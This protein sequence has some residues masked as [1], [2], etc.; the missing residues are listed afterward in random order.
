M[1]TNGSGVPSLGTSLINDYTLTSSTA[2]TVRTLTVTNTDNT[3]TASAALI[4]AVSGG[5]SAGDAAFQASTT[6]TVWS[7]GVDNSV[8]S[9]TADPFVVSQ[10]TALGTNNVISIATSG[11]IN[12]PLQPAFLAYLASAALNK[13]GA[14]ANYQLGTDAL[15]EVFDQNSD[16]NTNG[17]F[18]APVTGRYQLSTGC[19]FTGCTVATTFIVLLT[20]SNRVYRSQNGR[21]AGNGEMMMPIS[22]LADMD[23]ADTATVTVNVAGEAGNTV[24]IGT[25]SAATMFGG[26]LAC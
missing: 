7:L 22:A 4:K 25:D 24:D 16:F 13:T 18:T 19:Y 2:A 12:H 6:T 23:A 14:G 8:T 17:T 21:G 9:P 3:N 1:S 10:G 15:T 20:T 5:A 11:E 26:F